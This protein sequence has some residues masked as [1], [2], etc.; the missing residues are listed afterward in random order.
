MN[1]NSFDE[2]QEVL[3]RTR[4][5]CADALNSL[6]EKAVECLETGGKIVFFGNGGSASEAQHL[7]TELSVRFVR[8]RRALAGLALGANVSE[9]TACGNDYGFERIFARQ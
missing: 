6:I 7:A 2:H 1:L 9:V 4:T 3:S 5:T 8:H